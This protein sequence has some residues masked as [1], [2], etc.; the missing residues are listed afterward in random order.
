MPFA[1]LILAL[2]LAL[3]VPCLALGQVQSPAAQWLPAASQALAV[4][5][6]PT[7]QFHQVSVPGGRMDVKSG[8]L[9]AAY[10]I[11]ALGPALATPEM[12]ARAWMAQEG[13]AFGWST[14]ED[15]R[16]EAAIQTG[17]ST[18]LTFQQTF[19]GLPVHQ[20]Q[21]KVN[22]GPDGLPTMVVSAYAPHVADVGPFSTQP[23][24]SADRARQIA[25]RSVTTGAASSNEPALVVYPLDTPVLAWQLLVW[26]ERPPGEWEVL[27]DAQSG[28]VIHLLDRVRYHHGDDDEPQKT[29]KV[30]GKG[31]VWI[32]DPI[33]SA[34]VVYGGDYVDNDDADSDLLNDQRVEVTLRDIL[35]DTDNKYRLKGP[36]VRITDIVGD[37]YDAPA[38]DD[39][40]N[41]NYLRSDPRFEA[42]Q[43]YYHIDT[44]QRYVQSLALGRDIRTDRVNANPNG[45]GD[46][47]YASYIG[48][49]NSIIFGNGGV[50]T[51]E[52]AEV[53]WHEYGHALLDSS[54][55]GISTYEG[56]ALHEGWSDYWAVSYTR[57]LIEN[58]DVPTRDWRRVFDWNGNEVWDGRM[59]DQIGNYPDD[60]SC[61]PPDLDCEVYEDGVLWAT[62]LMEIY[63]RLGKKVTDRLNLLSHAYLSSA[64]TFPDAAQALIQAD[65]DHYQ[66]THLSDLNAILRARGLI[67]C[68]TGTVSNLRHTPPTSVENVPVSVTLELLSETCHGTVQPHRMYWAVDEGSFTKAQMTRI[69]NEKHTYD[70]LVTADAAKLRYYFEA[71]HASGD[72][73]WLPSGAPQTVYS[74]S[75][76][77]KVSVTLS[78]SP[79]SFDEGD[80]A[81]TFTLTGT[82]AGG[83]AAG[84]DLSL[85]IA[86]SGSGTSGVVG[87]GAVPSFDL[88]IA[89]GT[90]SGTATFTLTPSD[91]LV[92]QGQETIAISSTSTLV[93]GTASITLTDDDDAPSGIAL[94]VSPS[95][96]AEGDGAT[97][98]T[99]SAAVQGGTTYGLDTSLPI[100]IAGSGG[101]DVVG[102]TPVSDFTLTVPS[103]SASARTTFELT[104]TD[105]LVDESDETITISS[106]SGLVSGAVT[107]TLTDNDLPAQSIALSVSPTSLGEGDGATTF[108]LTGTLSSGLEALTDLSLPIAVSGSGN[109]GMVGFTAVPDFNLSI[110]AEGTQGSAT[111]V[112]TPTDNQVDESD[113]TIT[114]SSTSGLVSGPVTITLTDDDGAHAPAI[115]LA[116]SPESIS[117]SDDDVTITV[118]ATAAGE[119][120][121]SAQD[122]PITV[123]GSGVEGAVDFAAVDGFTL[124]MAAGSSAAEGTFQLTPVDDLSDETDETIT[125]SSTHPGVTATAVITVQDDD[126]APDGIALAA[127]PNSLGEG[128]G[129]TEIALIASVV[130]NTTYG[131]GR[132]LIIVIEGSGHDDVVGFTPVSD[133]TLTLP[134]GE[135]SVET[136]FELSPVDDDVGTGGEVVTVY[137][138]NPLVLSTAEI[139]I[140]DNDGGGTVLALSTSRTTISEG[141]ADSLITVIATLASGGTYST[142]QDIPITVQG[143]G[144]SAAVDFAAVPAFS[145]SLAPEDTEASG[146]FLLVP[147]DDAVDEEDETITIRST[148][149]A[150]G[151]PIQILLTDNDATPDGITL[152]AS[153]ATLYE[154][155]GPA[156][157]TLTGAVQGA[158]TYGLSQVLPITVSGSGGTGVVGFAPI[159]DFELTVDASTATAATTFTLEPV[160]DQDAESPE[161]I[162][163]STTSTLVSSPALI[164]LIDNDGGQ[165]PGIYLHT[166]P[167]T[168]DENAG[169]TTITVTASVLGPTYGD[170]QTLPIA[171]GP[172]GVEAAVDFAEV[173]AFDLSL[174]SG[175]STVSAHVTLSPSDDLVDEQD[176]RIAVTSTHAL[177][178]DTAYVTLVDD[179]DAPDGIR[180]FATPTSVGEGD[181][182]TQITIRGEVAGA[183]RYGATQAFPIRIRGSG[184]DTAVDFAPVGDFALSIAP[185]AEDGT[186]VFVLTP[187]DDLE[188]E[189]SETITIGSAHAAILSTAEVVL[190]DNDGATSAEPNEAQAGL[191]IAPP[192]PNPA[193]GVVSF[194]VDV[195]SHVDGVSLR[196]FNV[197]GQRVAT[198]FDGALQTGTYTFQFVGDHLAPGAYIYVLESPKSRQTG[199]LVVTG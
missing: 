13:T 6:D 10:G 25:L 133:F 164:T 87:F 36:Y 58:G 118:T 26:P 162:S 24:V 136:T 53:I 38:E 2:I 83:V 84:A 45:W 186:A 139:Y 151:S 93:S 198:L 131:A 57:G 134:G 81:T 113:E 86:V 150:A 182:P 9:R 31:M 167:T 183:T 99:L 97:T 112:L 161:V 187:I 137:S 70:V 176:E 149:P 132:E 32:P 76:G 115:T 152:S 15:L 66:G 138:T 153:P 130:G 50:D 121:V 180:L 129:L 21:V 123:S 102:F 117:E 96:V 91:D 16:L 34:G 80:G 127:E 98:I 147:D 104:P 40:T 169:D 3:F 154:G 41:F 124:S 28:S 20:R 174:A 122:V 22:L 100:A 52:D 79:T 33:T 109:T 65:I 192:F 142:A 60:Y 46:Y 145:L 14:T 48:G 18:H 199:R 62:T 111:F 179:D 103:A 126:A 54:V 19:R 166:Y 90:S 72:S 12:T 156:T 171:I 30:D 105:N 141:T 194:V 106:T 42:V 39:S 178:M 160:D 119:P 189:T 61:D 47:P 196:L 197:L 7:L 5:A 148:H 1:R 63:T 82:V 23:S 69:D 71:E 68:T 190:T 116:V 27:V 181:G 94:S 67:T 59:L 159:A 29:R 37:D 43:I 168:I 143:S 4:S 114:I 17:R 64:P 163:I 146:T 56:Y 184:D 172:S 175:A 110:A 89:S 165:V 191:R 8:I 44:S 73:V 101:N 88:S 120:L 155:D 78:V 157:V 188:Q 107:V 92:D 177:V 108:T 135:A 195:P 35:F 193:N 158:T 144:S 55:P 173:A 185:E 75:V 140:T 95:T 77:S 128:D 85:P 51:G 170:V 11:K 125:V 49:I 74:V